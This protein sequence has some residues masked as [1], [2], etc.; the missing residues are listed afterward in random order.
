[1][2]QHL[3][4]IRI[5]DC[6]AKENTLSFDLTDI[7]LCIVE[8][9]AD[10]KWTVHDVAGHNEALD[11]NGRNATKLESAKSKHTQIDFN[12]LLNIASGIDQCIWAE[13]HGQKSWT[14]NSPEI[15]IC[16]IDS[17]F[18]EVVTGDENV[19]QLLDRRF[20]DTD[21]IHIDS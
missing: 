15:V 13:F 20:I 16:A 10:F 12:E 3:F 1:L 2:K 18:W 11:I 8:L 19:V 14:S 17:T 5:R 6:D 9:T 4:R 21:I 7:L